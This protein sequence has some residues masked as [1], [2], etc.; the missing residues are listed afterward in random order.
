M[1]VEVI[2]PDDGVL[3]S[4]GILTNSVKSLLTTK[5][6]GFKNPDVGSV[7]DIYH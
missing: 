5:S 2:L 3:P 7:S 6:E 4:V 1:M